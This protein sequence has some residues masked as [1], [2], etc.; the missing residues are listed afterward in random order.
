MSI[1][2]PRRRRRQ[3]TKK[4]HGLLTRTLFILLLG[5][6]VLAV[7]LVVNTFRY[8]DEHPSVMPATNIRLDVDSVAARLGQALQYQT[9][10]DRDGARIDSSVFLDFHTF[11]QSAFPG[12]DSTLHRETVS[13]LSLLYIWQGRDPSLLPVLLMAHQDVVPADTNSVWEVPPFSGMVRDGFIW[14]RGAIDDKGSLMGILEAVEVL[15]R[16]GFVPN[17]T[18]YLAFGHDEEVLGQRGAQQ[19]AQKLAAEGIDL[20]FVLD[21]GGAI[22]EGVIEGLGN[23]VALI[24]VAEKGYASFQLSAVAAGGHSSVPPRHT[25]VGRLSRAITRLEE[26]LPRARID[27]ATAQMFDHIGPHLPFAQRMAFANRWLF[28]PALLFVFRSDPAMDATVRTTTAPTMFTGGIKDNVL[29]TRATA[30]VNFRIL[31][32]D[33]IEDVAAHIRTAVEDT[34]VTVQPYGL[35]IEPSPVSSTEAPG[36]ALLERSIR[37]VVSEQRIIVTPY[38]VTGATDSRYFTGLTDEVYRFAGMTMTPDDL[39]RFHGTNERIS[40]DSYTR[41]IHIY[42]QLLRNTNAALQKE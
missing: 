2:R 19:I 1:F 42:Y 39:K 18:I 9:I 26:R 28:D 37:E 3:R 35:Q 8:T 38:L 20:A 32:G 11:L 6:V 15:L 30:V 41:M 31:P 7:V 36:Y 34:L 13:D 22:T 25:A 23:P 17:R 29:P 33:R 5:L 12:I 16:D 40:L 10:S 24:G 4:N 14:G 21:E 27:G